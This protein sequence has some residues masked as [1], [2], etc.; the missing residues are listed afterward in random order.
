MGRAH[1]T[2]RFV[3]LLLHLGSEGLQLLVEA[4]H[5]FRDQAD[6]TTHPL[7]GNQQYVLVK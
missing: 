7:D 5:P 6:L 2:A 1:Q 3:E 4:H